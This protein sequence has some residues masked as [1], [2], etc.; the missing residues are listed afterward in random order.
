VSRQ[1]IA[2]RSSEWPDEISGLGTLV[3][4]IGSPYGDDRVGWEV[5]A[6]LDAALRLDPPLEPVRTCACDRPG[7]GLVGLLRGAQ[8]VIV[9]DAARVPGCAPGGLRWLQPPEVAAGTAASSHGF[10]VGQALALAQAL[11]ELPRDVNLLAI[12][13]ERFD[14]DALTE[15]VRAAVPCA[16]RAIRA[17]LCD[18]NPDPLSADGD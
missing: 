6:A 3:V 11:G 8:R 7:A 14:G 5:V 1:V 15:A 9:V 10:G 12:V 13:G 4:G 16:V 17:L 18:L 2:R